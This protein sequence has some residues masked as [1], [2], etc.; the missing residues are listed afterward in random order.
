MS[1]KAKTRRAN[2]IKLDS[3]HASNNEKNISLS[4][5]N[6]DKVNRL[7]GDA[8][9]VNTSEHAVAVEIKAKRK[10]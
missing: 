10:K 8:V 5:N 4:S 1:L 9:D 3:E 2:T 7:I 6:L